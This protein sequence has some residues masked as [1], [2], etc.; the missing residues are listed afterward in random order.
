MGGAKGIGCDNVAACVQVIQMNVAQD[1]QLLVCVKR[2]GRP[3]WQSDVH[4]SA[5]EFRT[6]GPIKQKMIRIHA[7]LFCFWENNRSKTT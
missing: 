5:I 2:I 4:A 7:Q 1:I 6:G 3:L